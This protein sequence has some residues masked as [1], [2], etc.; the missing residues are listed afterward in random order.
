MREYFADPD[1]SWSHHS[2]RFQQAVRH[3]LLV[4][5]EWAAE[6]EEQVQEQG[7][8]RSKGKEGAGMQKPGGESSGTQNPGGEGSRAGTAGGITGRGNDYPPNPPPGQ[9]G[10]RRNGSY[11]PKHTHFGGAPPPG[12]GPPPEGVPSSDSS[13]NSSDS[14]SE[15]GDESD[16]NEIQWL[17][18]KLK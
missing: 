4:Q 10:N 16:M 1:R 8:K 7:G 3:L 11:S 18:K 2:T 5:A 14:G 17:R 6:E 13:N 15:G 9:S 12:G